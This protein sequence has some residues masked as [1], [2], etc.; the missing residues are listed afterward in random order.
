MQACEISFVF[1]LHEIFVLLLYFQGATETDEAFCKDRENDNADD[2]QDSDQDIDW[3]CNEI[4]SDSDEDSYH[5]DE[6]IKK[7]DHTNSLD[8]DDSDEFVSSKEKNFVE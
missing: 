6:D 5:P 7:D 3:E 2:D 8:E 1:Q 4:M